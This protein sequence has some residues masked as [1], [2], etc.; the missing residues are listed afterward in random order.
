ML[1]T[2]I[3]IALL[4]V[5]ILSAQ[6]AFA[7][8]PGTHAYI[9]THMKGIAGANQYN[10]MYAAVVP[11][12]NQMMS[13]DQNSK[14]FY[15]T[16][17]DPQDLWAVQNNT[18]A[19]HE[20][21]FGYVTHNEAFGADHFAH[22]FSHQYPDYTNPYQ[23]VY[24]GQDGYVWQKADQLCTVMKQEFKGDPLAQALLA[25]PAGLM[26]CHFI[27]EYGMDI[28]L[29]WTKDPLLGKKLM[30]SVALHDSQQ[31]ATLLV[32]GYP[33]IG[34]EFIVP[35]PELGGYSPYQAWAGT[36]MAYAV[37]L[38][39]PM[40]IDQGKDLY[41]VSFFL[42]NLALQMLG[43]N[44][45]VEMIQPLIYAGLID[46]ILLTKSDY[47]KELTATIGELNGKLAS[48]KMKF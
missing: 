39:K 45:P 15:A 37:A 29:K 25:G 24:P 13:T 32:T 1:R 6:S 20:L 12:I 44:V 9:A 18:A 43:M 36:V 46:S 31:M 14:Y 38:D 26:N 34:T 10:L 5:A 3:F 41:E 16:H 11:D 17:Y 40:G 2:R 22:I 4:V 21:A 47:P 27:V 19:Q 28:V 7:W 42:S 8:A 33:D 48:H 30:A 35:K 23:S